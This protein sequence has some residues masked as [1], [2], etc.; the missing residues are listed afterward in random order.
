MHEHKTTAERLGAF[1]DAVIAVIITIMVLELKAPEEAA[2]FGMLCRCG[3]LPGQL[4]DQLPVHRN[5]L[6][7]SPSPVA[8]ASSM[9]LDP[10]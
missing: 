2:T 10:R 5:H 1:S 4:R 8:A 3:R 6:D 9:C 7:Q